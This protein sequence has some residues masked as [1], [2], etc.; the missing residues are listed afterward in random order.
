MQ[1]VLANGKENDEPLKWMHEHG[2]VTM[3]VRFGWAWMQ[4]SRDRDLA[5]SWRRLNRFLDPHQISPVPK[6]WLRA[7]ETVKVKVKMAVKGDQSPM[8]V[9]P[10]LANTGGRPRV[11]VVHPKPHVCFVLQLLSL[12]G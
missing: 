8:W 3:R 9:A 4:K 2:L 7:L 1:V 10:L 12:P 5:V 11:A 6:P